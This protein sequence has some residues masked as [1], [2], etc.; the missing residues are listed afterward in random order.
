MA[1]FRK[2]FQARSSL[3]VRPT[4]HQI[5]LV[6]LRLFVPL[7][8]AAQHFEWLSQRLALVNEFVR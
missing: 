7:F 2:V 1:R 3:P 6:F 8:A 4:A 5:P